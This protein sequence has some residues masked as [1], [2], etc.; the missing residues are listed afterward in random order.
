MTTLRDVPDAPASWPL[1]PIEELDLYLENAQEPSLVAL[2]THTRGHLD[3]AALEA[4]LTAV[5]AADPSARRHL[6]ATSRWS[7]RLRWEAAAPGRLLTVTG[8]SS[9]GQLAALR[10]QLSAWPMSLNDTAARVLL[11]VGPEH[12]VVILQTHHAAF[13]GI[14][15]L[16]LLSAICAAYRDAAGAGVGPQTTAS[17]RRARSCPFL[18]PA[19]SGPA[20]VRSSRRP[21]TG[22]G[23]GRQRRP[24]GA[25]PL[26]PAW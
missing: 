16:A 26:R 1:A 4:A 24:G 21:R 9:P 3:R 22:P 11:A 6:A 13:D 12:D 19:L 10:E 17:A 18:G 8:W 2:E 5:L 7:R 15:S 20:R 14:S 23:A 25:C